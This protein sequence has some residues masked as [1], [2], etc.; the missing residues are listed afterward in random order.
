MSRPA[1]R[2]LDISRQLPPS[3]A[4]RYAVILALVIGAIVA[5]GL[6]ALIVVFLVTAFGR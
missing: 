2:G 6:T 5:T 3:G 4:R 1:R